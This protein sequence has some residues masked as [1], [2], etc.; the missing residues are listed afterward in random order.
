M[1]NINWIIIQSNDRESNYGVGTSVKIL[2][3]GIIK[4]PRN[5][6][7]RFEVRF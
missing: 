1:E 7:L 3:G 4:T 5:F 2:Y 6:C